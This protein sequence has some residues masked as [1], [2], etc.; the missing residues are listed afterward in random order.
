MPKYVQA[1]HDFY[2]LTDAADHKNFLRLD[3]GHTVGSVFSERQVSEKSR[4]STSIVTFW[5]SRP[6]IIHADPVAASVRMIE[7]C[8]FVCEKARAQAGVGACGLQPA[9]QRVPDMGMGQNEATRNWTAGFGP[10]FHL[11][12]FHFG[13]P[14]LTHQPHGPSRFGK[15]SELRLWHNLSLVPPGTQQ[16]PSEGHRHQGLH[17][18]GSRG[19]PAARPLR[20]RWNIA[21]Q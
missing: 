17:V 19:A 4:D 3:Q 11:P 10:C 1:V 5:G 6:R 21:S 13:Y 9:P 18:C 2:S 14:F 15:P 7:H 20:C 8:R 16:L 12:G